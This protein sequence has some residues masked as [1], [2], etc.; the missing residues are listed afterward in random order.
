MLMRITG[1]SVII[2]VEDIATYVHHIFIPNKIGLFETNYA[3]NCIDSNIILIF[4]CF[5][6]AMLIDLL[7]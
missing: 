2:Y 4:Y 5:F 7:I 3:L 6:L 1:T